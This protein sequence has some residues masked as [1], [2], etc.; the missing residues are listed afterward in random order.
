MDLFN[1]L[2][3]E[4]LKLKKDTMFYIGTIIT[5]LVPVLVILKDKV[6]S[7]PPKSAMDW[8][9]TCCL[10]DFL[11]L[12]IL[13]GLVIT[14]LVQ[15]E[16]QSGTLTNILT[17]AVSRTSFVF[18]KLVIWFFWYFILLVYIEIVTVLG[19]KFIYPDEFSMDFVKIVIAMFT[20]FGLLSFITFIPL[21]WVTI[22]QKKL[23]YPSVLVAIA[24]TGI[25]VGGFNISLDMIFLASL[26]PWT[27]V[28]LI[29]IY[30]V[31]SPYIII[32]II[33]IVLIGIIGLFLSIRSINKQEQ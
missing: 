1:V 31:E 15:K 23:F 5:M 12:S 14:N 16:Y 33:S 32:G 20:K 10:V 21:L 27:A 24:F 8:V 17:S 25:L 11:I 6:I 7:A 29:S 3:S 30:Q 18:S 26:I 28:S 22:L 13:S 4:F 2:K 9:M 19:S